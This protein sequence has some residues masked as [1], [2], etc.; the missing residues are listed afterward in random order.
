MVLYLFLFVTQKT[1]VE[2]T[3]R[4]SGREDRPEQAYPSHRPCLGNDELH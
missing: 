3:A 1:E 2:A 4:W